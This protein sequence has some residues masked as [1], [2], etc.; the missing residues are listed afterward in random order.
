MVITEKHKQKENKYKIQQT[1]NYKKQKINKYANSKKQKA[2][3]L[4]THV[5]PS[6]E[7]SDPSATAIT[8]KTKKNRKHL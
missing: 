4:P 3:K 6:V 7:I 2:S 1:R 5:H 8:H